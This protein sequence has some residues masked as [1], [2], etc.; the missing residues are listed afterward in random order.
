M[1]S[2]LM[3]MVPCV[4][5]TLPLKRLTWFCRSALPDLSASTSIGLLRSA[6]SAHAVGARASKA[7][8]RARSAVQ[9]G[10][11]GEDIIGTKLAGILATSSAPDVRAAGEIRPHSAAWNRPGGSAALAGAVQQEVC[12]RQGTI[13][14]TGE[15]G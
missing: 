4:M 11:K 8:T 5:T 10:G 3:T 6:F 13:M 2:A 15:R 7:S 12:H 14:A 9:V 1:R